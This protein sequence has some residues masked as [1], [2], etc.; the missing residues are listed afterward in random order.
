MKRLYSFLSI[1]FVVTF[2]FAEEKIELIGQKATAHYD[3]EIE[4]WGDVWLKTKS[5]TVLANYLKYDKKSS[6]IRSS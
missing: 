2:L 5:Y 3:G 1:F 4:G 6:Y